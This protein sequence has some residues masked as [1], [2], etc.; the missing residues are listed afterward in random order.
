[1]CFSF[2]SPLLFVEET[3][4]SPLNI[5]GSLVKYYLTIYTRFNSEL[6]SVP[7]IDVSTFV[8]KPY[9]FYYC[10]FL[11]C[12]KFRRVIPPALFFFLS[13]ILAIQGIL[14]FHI[15]FSIVSSISGILVEIALNLQVVWELYGHF[16]YINSS[17]PQMWDA[18][19][20][21]CAFFISF[22]QS[23]VVFIVQIFT[24]LITFIPQYVILIL[25]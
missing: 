16:N 25:V 24:S 12:L 6:C 4:F 11:I 19:P 21:V 18:F 23:I 3:I 14:W 5:F 20:F 13:I 15:N 10:G 2:F 1:M 17:N 22:Q 9:C 7:L 8:P